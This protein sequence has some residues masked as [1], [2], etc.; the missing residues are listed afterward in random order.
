MDRDLLLIDK[1]AKG[2]ETTFDN[3]LERTEEGSDQYL[4]FQRAFEH[5]H[6]Y[7][8]A[9]ILYGF[10]LIFFGKNFIITFVI[11]E[12]FRQGGSE[13]LL[14]YTKKLQGKLRRRR[15]RFR[16]IASKISMKKKNNNISMEEQQKETPLLEEEEEK[17]TE[18][19][20]SARNPLF[21]NMKQED[22][23]GSSSSNNIPSHVR[24]EEPLSNIEQ[25]EELDEDYIRDA[26]SE[27]GGEAINRKGFLSRL[28]KPLMAVLFALK[29][30]VMQYVS[31]GIALGEDFDRALQRFVVPMVLN[32]VDSKYHDQIPQLV[33]YFCRAIGVSISVLGHRYVSI[34][35]TSVRG[36][37]TCVIN[38]QQIFIKENIT[39]LNQDKPTDLYIVLILILVGILFQTFGYPNLP[40]YVRFAFLPAF[41]LEQLR[42]IALIQK[43]D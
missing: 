21:D 30:K 2:L 17:E 5:L 28:S 40:V 27:A 22:N 29:M 24:A 9:S 23:E 12:A 3:A 35:V 43:I 39:L 41:L 31:L 36:A 38:L 19:R 32:R 15:K 37:F 42:V 26:E 11:M 25:E 7:E 4:R 14:K 33:T 34:L 8:I 18:G 1:L 13:K 16:N 6:P 20:I 10:M